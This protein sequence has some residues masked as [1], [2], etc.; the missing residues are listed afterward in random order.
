[1]K[2]FQY[3]VAGYLDRNG[4]QIPQCLI[5][6]KLTEVAWAPLPGSQAAFLRCPE[7]EVL[8]EGTRGGCGKTLALLMDFLQFVGI[9]MGP[10][11]KGIILRRTF[12]QLDEVIS[13]SRIWIPKIF[14]DARYNGNEH[15]WTF[16]DG[17]TLRFGFLEFPE[18]FEQNYQGKS[19]TFV[20]L[21]ELANW[22]TPEC[23]RLM[24]SCLR[25]GHPLA[26]LH[27]R[28]TCNTF[29]V[30]ADWIKERYRLPLQPFDRTVG[31]A[32]KDAVDDNGRPEP[33][34][35]VVHGSILENLPLMFANPDYLKNVLASTDNAAKAEA[36]GTGKW[37][38]NPEGVFFDIDWGPVIVPKF[39]P[40]RVDRISI[41]LDWGDSAPAVALFW[42][43]GNGEAIELPDGTVHHAAPGSVYLLDEVYMGI[44]NK[45]LG[46]TIAEQAERI[47][48]RIIERDWSG[49]ILRREGN[50]AD[51]SI[52]DTTPNLN[53]RSSYAKEFEKCGIRFEPSDKSPG[54]RVQGLG[55]ARRML[56]A[57]A[58]PRERPS[59][60]ICD[61][62]VNWLA[63]VPKLQR[64]KHDPEDCSTEGL[65]HDWDATRYFLR[66]E[67][68]PKVRFGSIR[69]LYP[70]AIGR[71]GGPSGGRPRTLRR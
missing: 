5:G 34:R 54:S 58:P 64:A 24:I 45:G 35:R 63:H 32:I 31:P 53:D 25:S 9:G 41:S 59:L 2:L 30:G 4:V 21:E 27:L 7:Y 60:H 70:N 33:H 11:H 55:V 29:G 46:L 67:H 66:R 18:Q 39:E 14:P 19:F 1:M 38:E 47:K 17:A 15:C 61:N 6:D 28:A 65:D 69:T 40:P 57:A 51:A 37:M 8:F 10:E 36:W 68:K 12:P 52:F 22:P 43:V 26:R 48:A 50:I 23:L 62:N 16:P 71:F 20:G 3:E 49:K 44:K 42:Y 13:L 56:R